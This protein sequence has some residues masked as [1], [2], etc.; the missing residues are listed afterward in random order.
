MWN[1]A[2]YHAKRITMLKLMGGK[3]VRCGCCDLD[4]LEFGHTQPRTWIPNRLNRMQRL[5]RY[6]QDWEAGLIEVQCRG[7][8]NR[9][10]GLMPRWKQLNQL[11][12]KSFDMGTVKD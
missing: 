3:C 10:N 1:S 2:S 8:N 7:C 9:Q 12:Q 4:Q 11:V 5:R 6:W